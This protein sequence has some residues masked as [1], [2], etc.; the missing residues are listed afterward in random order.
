M[1]IIKTDYQCW[2]GT[3]VAPDHRGG[4]LHPNSGTSCDDPDPAYL[5]GG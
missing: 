1:S 3:Y 5:P 4:W 2:H